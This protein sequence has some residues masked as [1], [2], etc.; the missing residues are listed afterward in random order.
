MNRKP[1][2]ISKISMIFM[3]AALLATVA[4]GGKNVQTQPPHWKAA[5]NDM[6][7]GNTWYMRGCLDKAAIYFDKA[8]ERFSAFDDREGVAKC[9]NNLG[10]IARIKK[11][12]DTALLLLDQA[13]MIFAEINQPMGQ[14]QALSNQAAVHIDM[15]QY[16]E[17]ETAL[18]QAESLAATHMLAYPPLSSNRALVLIHGKDF[19]NARALLDQAMMNTTPEKPFE[20]ATLQHV[21]GFLMESMGH[22]DKA[23][24]HYESALETDR[25]HYFLRGIAADLAAMGRVFMALDQPDKAVTVLYRSLGVSTL[26]GDGADA[27]ETSA[28]LKTGL[29][30]LGERAPDTRITDLMLNQWAKGDTV[31]APCE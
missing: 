3:T 31:S 11:D 12:R 29:T 23:L 4:C 30:T 22:L 24:P 18:D 26:L 13:R 28:L 9:M 5:N 6:I 20:W 2:A 16:T 19:D 15:G 14:I 10:S 8:L 7:E 21:T 1:I 27:G 17:A 25:S